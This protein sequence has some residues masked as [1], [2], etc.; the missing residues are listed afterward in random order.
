MNYVSGTR[1]SPTCGCAFSPLLWERQPRNLPMP[2]QGNTETHEL[3]VDIGK[4]EN[5]PAREGDRDVK[6]IFIRA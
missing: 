1:P 2:W 6:R 4:K 5:S 3:P